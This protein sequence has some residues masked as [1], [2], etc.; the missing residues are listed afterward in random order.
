ME[1]SPQKLL[2]GC[3]EL[4]PGM[5]RAT[6]FSKL[7]LLE[8]ASFMTSSPT[9]KAVRTWREKSPAEA[10]FS[11]LAHRALVESNLAP[12]EENRQVAA[13][14]ADFCE[15]LEAEAVVF[16]TPASFVPSARNRERMSAFFGEVA[17][18]ESFGETV[19]VF[20]PDGLWEPGEIAETCDSLGLLPAVDALMRDPFE[21]H[22]AFV[23]EQIATGSVY[24]RLP[25][26]GRAKRRFEPWELE[27][28]GELVRDCPRAWVLFGNPDKYADAL[29]FA[30]AMGVV[31]SGDA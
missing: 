15:I 27:E 1:N 9:R 20:A 18:A 5:S 14:L 13:E 12:S 22:R 4:P 10:R 16:R 28:L 2:V 3:A 26:L 31:D 23:H 29:R 30:R 6:Y 21:E 19:R 24:M 11:V 17:T 7:P 8:I 25:G